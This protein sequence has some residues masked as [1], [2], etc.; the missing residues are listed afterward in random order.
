MFKMN[1]LDVHFRQRPAG[2]LKLNTMKREKRRGMAENIH[3]ASHKCVNIYI[4]FEE[5]QYTQV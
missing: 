4:L 2:I 5:V 3:S 1:E